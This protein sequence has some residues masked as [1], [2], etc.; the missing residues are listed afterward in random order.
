MCCSHSDRDTEET[1]QTSLLLYAIV[2]YHSRK[3][4]TIN[5]F[6][7]LWFTLH[8]VK[9]M[10][11]DWTKFKVIFESDHWM[12]QYY[13]WDFITLSFVINFMLERY[14]TLQ[15]P[16]C[17]AKICLS[18]SYVSWVNWALNPLFQLLLYYYYIIYFSSMFSLISY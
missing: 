6:F 13:K 18:P 11:L 14:Q 16:A 2:F 9:R 3:N 1:T 5:S 10:L 7:P 12:V 15:H 8:S 17:I 4:K